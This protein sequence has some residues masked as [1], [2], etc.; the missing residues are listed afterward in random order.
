MS[1]S[2]IR[3]ATKAQKDAQEARAKKYHIDVKQGGNVTKPSEWNDL[4][5]A[6]FA[7][8]VNYAYPMPDKAHADNAAARWGDAANREQYS[9]EEQAIIEKRIEARQKSF[10]EDPDA[11]DEKNGAHRAQAVQSVYC[12]A[13]I[14]RIDADKREVEGVLSDEQIDTY[15]TIFDYDAMKGAVER[16]IGNIREQHDISKAVGKRVSAVFD[17]AARQIILRSRVSLGAEDTWQ[18]VLDGTL[19]GYSVGV[20]R[21]ARPQ[22]QTRN[23]QQVP[24]FTDFDLF[25]VSLVDAPSNPGA[26]Q[27]GLTIYRSVADVCDVIEEPTPAPESTPEPTP[28]PIEEPPMPSTLPTPIVTPAPQPSATIP[29]APVTRAQAEGTDPM[30]QERGHAHAEHSH[31]HTSYDEDHEHDHEHTHQDGTTHSHPHMHIHDHHA[32]FPGGHTHPHTHTHDHE[33][34]YRFAAGDTSHRQEPYP[35]DAPVTRAITTQTGLQ[36]HDPNAEPAFPIAEDGTHA[37]MTGTHTH[38]HAAYGDEPDHT[39]EHTHTDDASHEPSDDHVHEEK[40]AI[41]APS[42][43]RAGAAISAATR[44]GLH[45]GVLSIMRTCNCPF[46]QEA[47]SVYDPDNDGDDDADALGDTD[48]DSAQ[49]MRHIQRMTRATIQ[50]AL[51]QYL[52]PIAVQYRAIATRF[53]TAQQTP[54]VLPQLAEM[55][56]SLEAVA[57]VVQQI[58]QQD[59]G[60]GPV[61]RAVDRTLATNQTVFD[62]SA[63]QSGAL[64][65]QDYVQLMQA[66]QSGALSAEQQKDAA[67]AIIQRLRKQ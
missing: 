44:T 13:P 4:S 10:G 64:T 12:Y 60:G 3:S 63:Q 29:Q 28:P 33:H 32:H 39:H 34:V 48:N 55:R 53:T 40:R 57:Q 35:E 14:T 36:G 5:D 54:D 66:S 43:T 26:A 22:L 45:E 49:M 20:G 42:L 24:V 18:K 50:H 16:W 15:G 47:A 1:V 56:A 23:G 31:M 2:V 62:A 52:A 59:R 11:K 38:K 9:A 46:C 8:P 58:A 25:E 27:S 21:Y 6:D 41:E 51:Q 67:A 7:D 17:D 65:Q 37:K 61:L 19:S 30:E